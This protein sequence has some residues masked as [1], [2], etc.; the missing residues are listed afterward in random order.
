MGAEQSRSASNSLSNMLTVY[1]DIPDFRDFENKPQKDDG[2]R[3]VGGG[4]NVYNDGVTPAQSP[5]I[6]WRVEYDICPIYQMSPFGDSIACSICSILFLH[7]R[8]ANTG[9]KDSVIS[10]RWIYCSYLES[11]GITSKSA[12]NAAARPTR[13]TI[14]EV[15]RYIRRHGLVSES[16]CRS[17]DMSLWDKPV[18]LQNRKEAIKWTIDYT[19][20]TPDAIVTAL[21]QKRTIL[22]AISVFSNFLHPEVRQSGYISMPD[23]NMDSL[24]GMMSVVIVGY[25]PAT[26][27]W[28]IRC[29]L[30][31]LWGDHGY[32]F[33][34]REY[35]ARNASDF[36]L[37]SLMERRESIDPNSIVTEG[38]VIGDGEGCRD[39][40]A[41]SGRRSGDDRGD[42]GESD[43]GPGEGSDGGGDRIWNE[44]MMF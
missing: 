25:H 4:V 21:L 5:S 19:R 8:N 35:L 27:R 43:G 15:L 38:I 33:I 22:T 26:Q 29:H 42:R 11:L 20:I 30:G 31:P 37:V 41:R 24:L 44:R 10:R 39:A 9:I 32:G 3:V 28:I 34:D 7:W 17:V 2:S 12:Q 23:K 1:P 40:S 14:R 18:S 36:W 13:M 16:S 6:D